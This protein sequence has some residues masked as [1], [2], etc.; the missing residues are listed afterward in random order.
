MGGIM[1]YAIEMGSGGMIHISIF[2]K[3][4]AG[5]WNGDRSVGIAMWLLA[6]SWMVQV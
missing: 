2:I 6:T 3:I 4:G 1:K 5:I